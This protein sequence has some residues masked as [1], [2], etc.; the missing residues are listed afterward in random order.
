MSEAYA[1][2]TG[3][4]WEPAVVQKGMGFPTACCVDPVH[5]SSSPFRSFELLYN[6]PHKKTTVPKGCSH[7]NLFLCCLTQPRPTCWCRTRWKVPAGLSPWAAEFIPWPRDVHSTAQHRP[8]PHWFFSTAQPCTV[9]GGLQAS[10]APKHEMASWSGS[11]WGR[12]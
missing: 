9:S 10:V 12:D 7:G 5:G 4:C 11:K 2:S 3:Q 8:E 6:S 1:P